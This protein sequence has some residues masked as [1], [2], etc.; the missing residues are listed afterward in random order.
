M[1]GGVELVKAFQ[2]LRENYQN[3][4]LT[5]VTPVHTLKE[6]HVTHLKSI[7]G[8]TLL[9]AKMDAE[10]M[11]RLYREHDVFC[12]PT[13]RDGF[14]LVLIE[15]LAYGMPLITTEQYATP[16][17]V[18]ENKNGFVY[19]GHPLMDYEPD[20]YRLL[21]RYY[22]PKKFYTNLF[23]FQAEGK[24][25]PVEDFITTSIK[26]FLDSPAIIEQFSK[27]SISLYQKKF[28]PDIIGDQI[29][30]VFLNAIKK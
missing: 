5:L 26:V 25:K 3:V 8:L 11:R 22:N 1:K 10:G 18:Q 15:A 16:E 28:R 29:E 13:Y 7:S 14:G 27:Q 19:H 23:K 6:S 2:R 17:M 20:T 24:L 30:R 21:G 4:E 12:L 9:D